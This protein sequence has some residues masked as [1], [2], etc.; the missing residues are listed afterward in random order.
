[1]DYTIVGPVAWSLKHG[2]ACSVPPNIIVCSSHVVLLRY[3]LIQPLGTGLTANHPMK[4]FSCFAMEDQFCTQMTFQFP[5][6][7]LCMTLTAL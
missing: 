5:L 1:M 7:T 6:M 4:A 2:S 3:R